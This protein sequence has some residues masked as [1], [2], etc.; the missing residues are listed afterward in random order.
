MNAGMQWSSQNLPLGMGYLELVGRLLRIV[1]QVII[2]YKA[3]LTIYL[4]EWVVNTSC[5]FD[6]V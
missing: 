5:P 2:T 6:R 1:I 4:K 3:Q